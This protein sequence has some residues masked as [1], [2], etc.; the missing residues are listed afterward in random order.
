MSDDGSP[1]T[2]H[3]EP[4]AT[5]PTGKVITPARALVVGSVMFS[6]IS[7]WRT[8][9]VVLC[10][11]A[12]TAY[13]IG[14]IVEQSIGPAMPWFIAA[15][16]LFTY[17][18][19]SVYMESCAMF[20]RGGV[21]RVVKSAMGGFLAKVSVSALLFD[22]MLTGPTSSVSAGQYLMG[23]L[24]DSLAFLAPATHRHLGLQDAAVRDVIKRWGS[25]C[26]AVLITGYFFRQNVLGMREAS[27][28][29]LKIMAATSVVIVLVLVWGSI[30]VAVRGP[31]NR[32]HFL[33]DF[34]KKVEY[35][36]VK[37]RD[38]VT[39]ETK[40]VWAID[41]STGKPQPK[42][43]A[44]TG[45]IMPKLNPVTG[46]QD[47]PLG[48]LP[49]VA[50]EFAEKLRKPTS[51]LG[52]F[53]L[54]GLVLAFGHSI[55]AMSGEETLAQVYREVEAPKLSNLKKAAFIVFVYSFIMTVGISILAVLI[56][57]DEVRIKDYADNLIGGV[58]MYVVGPP[59]ARLLLN[60]LVVV[61]GF[62]IL[63]GAVNTSIIGANGVLNRV[64]E[65]GVMPSWFLR[66]HPRYGTSHRILRLIAGMQL[67]TILGSRG[68]VYVL[69]E[70][71]A[72]GLVWCFVFNSL[73]MLLLRF[74][75][76]S[77]R[78]YKV[79][80]NVRVRGVE[81][82]VGLALIFLILLFSA[83]SN[84][85]TKEIATVGGLAFTT[86]FLTMFT[87]TERLGARRTASE[88]VP[89]RLTQFS[90]K[91][92]TGVDRASLELAK[93]YCLLVSIRSSQNLF[94]LEKALSETDPEITD[95]VV[96]T[97]KVVRW[98]EPV[99]T[100]VSE[101]DK[102]DRDLMTAVLDRAEAAGK[103]VIPLIIP[104]N[105]ALYAIVRTAKDLKANQLVVGLSNLSSA[106]D[107]ISVLVREW[108]KVNQEVSVRAPLSVRVLSNLHDI[109]YD[110]DGGN[111]IPTFAERRAR[112]VAEL[113]WAGVGVQ[114]VLVL[115]DGS[116]YGSDLFAAML[117]VLD[118]GVELA[119]VRAPS[120]RRTAVDGEAILER[121]RLLAE[122]L[123][124][125]IR[126]VPNG[127][128]P[129]SIA[130]DGNHGLIVVPLANDRSEP[131]E[132]WVTDIL[133]R[134]HCLV[135]LA[136]PPAI[137]KERAEP[138][139]PRQGVGEVLP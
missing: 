41:P 122:H 100:E 58:A 85:L 97:A 71:Y 76:R 3:P 139:E 50:P 130:R 4:P 109:R 15:V 38:R 36:V 112:S 25:V 116:P 83:V 118:P 46:E 89:E 30:T 107:Q 6:F 11:L 28:K 54:L 137:P 102:Y 92:A 78:E 20:V 111:R 126:L 79:P 108:R 49:R 55:L 129:V 51:W 53:G 91:P 75:D 27:G 62:L 16:M 64:A 124:R 7:C 63:A 96:M 44:V 74:R 47:D 22:Y 65:D 39:G 115:H 77:P 105:D 67:L 128:D 110:V 70:A 37:A 48:F 113:R 101:L 93:P 24:I 12:S 29:A 123:N 61:V 94:M 121:D 56:V 119:V 88:E 103:T 80:L 23:L 95:I 69:G 117:T 60:V 18:V 13:Y 127:G 52:L 17:A 72:F 33:P 134:A 26:V 120:G 125:R 90:Q 34:S 86:L 2:L 5:E 114:K 31:M 138:H 106:E 135:L 21:Y 42:R 136:A 104:T 133:A 87:I 35:Q 19:R 57:P 1:P 68:D 43:D 66:P 40:E 9:A 99:S 14:G 73:S 84:T 8:A 10:D 45:R 98:V 82:P 59:I 32:L 131:P 132:P 81:V